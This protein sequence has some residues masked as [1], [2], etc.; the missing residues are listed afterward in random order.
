M[1]PTNDP[2]RST[3]TVGA[4]PRPQK[5]TAGVFDT[6]RVAPDTFQSVMF[7]SAAARREF[8]EGQRLRDEDKPQKRTA[9][10]MPLWSVQLAAVNWR[11][12]AQLITITIPMPGN[13]VDQFM[14]GDP[15]QLAGMVFG[16]SPKRDGGGFVTWC[17]ADSLEPVKALV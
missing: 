14:P 7:M 11:G 1:Y 15:V 9:D 13:P 6:V 10:G 17:S 3:P 8:V 2:L 4:L 12:N 5:R 16:V